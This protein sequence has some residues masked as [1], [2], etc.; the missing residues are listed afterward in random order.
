MFKA[1]REELDKQWYPEFEAAKP[2]PFTTL[3]KNNCSSVVQS[4]PE[5]NYCARNKYAA[6]FLTFTLEFT[7][8]FEFIS[9]FTCAVVASRCIDT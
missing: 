3:K 9:L 4:E 6:L 2:F 5:N 1:P 7:V 8:L